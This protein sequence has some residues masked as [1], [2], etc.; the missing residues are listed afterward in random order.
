MD[1]ARAANATYE[2]GDEGR[3]TGSVLLRGSLRAEDGTNIGVVHFAPGARTHWHQHAGGQFLYA[4]AGRGRVRS[5]DETGHILEPGDVIH[6]EPGE[7]HFHGGTPDAPL[8]HV[9]ING[10]GDAIWGDPVTDAE[11]AEGF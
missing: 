8:L 1:I 6:V 11:Y 2:Q 5:Q 9:A 4:I 3:F 7:W 10:G